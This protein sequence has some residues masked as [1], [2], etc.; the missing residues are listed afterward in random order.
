M[1]LAEHPA[2]AFQHLLLKPPRPAQVALLTERLGKV[3]HRRQRIRMRLAVYPAEAFQRLLLK[4]PRPAQVALMT[5]HYGK[6]PPRPQRVRMRLAV[7]PAEAFQR[8][9]LK[10]PRPAQLALMNERAGK[11]QHRPQ[12]IRMRLAVYPAAGFQHL[13]LKPPRPAQVALLT[14][15]EGKV[16]HRRQ[17]IRI[18]RTE[19]LPGQFERPPEQ[20]PGRGVQRRAEPVVS[21]NTIQQPAQRPPIERQRLHPVE[22]LQRLRVRRQRC[23][24]RPVLRV[25]GILRTHCPQHRQQAARRRLTFRNPQPRHPLRQPVQR[26]GRSGS[27]RFSRRRRC[28][29]LAGRQR[30]AQQ[31]ADHIV[32]VQRIGCCRC[33]FG[34]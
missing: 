24:R 22:R 33:Q 23:E 25:L 4:P 19:R 12:R 15:R 1:R 5:E 31:L 34:R 17:R 32:P 30:I 16:V 11:V 28:R 14:E 2:V 10:P 20:R 21:G 27:G 8:L 18:I 6:V 3:Q 9:L 26:Q 13:L 7:Y 29:F